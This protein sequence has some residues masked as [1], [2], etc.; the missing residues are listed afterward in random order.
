[1]SSD[2]VEKCKKFDYTIPSIVVD[3]FQRAKQEAFLRFS[4][5]CLP[6]EYESQDVNHAMIIYYVIHA[7]DT[8]GLLEPQPSK[9]PILTEKDRHDLIEY[10]Y[11][12]QIHATEAARANDAYGFG[13]SG[14]PCCVKDGSR[15][16]VSSAAT[17]F[18]SL[19]VLH[20]L[21]DDLSRVDRDS[22]AEGFRKLQQPNG[23]V[24]GAY[25]RKKLA[26]DASAEEKA[27][28]ALED[29][30]DCDLRFVFCACASCAMLGDWR[31]IDKEAATRYILSCQSYDGAFGQGPLQEGHGG[32]TFCAVASLALMD[33][34]GPKN[35][36]DKYD[37]D[38]KERVCVLSP[39]RRRSLVRWL[40]NRQ[41]S[42][43]QGRINK[44]PDTCYGFWI[45]ASLAILRSRDP[46]VPADARP[47][48]V[49]FVNNAAL[50]DF[51]LTCQQN[52]GGFSKE[53]GAYPDL[54][55]TCLSMVAL[56]IAGFPGMEEV[57]C[58]LNITKR[59]ARSVVKST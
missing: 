34:L 42:G 28:S 3:E 21:G 58:A 46:D 31:G 52:C 43:F 12:L 47:S 9:K 5:Q 29:I 10:I 30:G 8:L 18:G 33:K 17:T 35:G 20:E 4:V 1:M 54:V 59:A 2:S 56:S 39:E 40:V 38:G 11:S 50:C 13:F 26:D 22:I 44:P 37:A 32:S 45:G 51:L 19:C 23:C 15:Y 24:A 49:S 55:H 25:Q 41:V 14:A 57:D 27:L 7:I 6:R 16:L 53:A 48:E 36:E